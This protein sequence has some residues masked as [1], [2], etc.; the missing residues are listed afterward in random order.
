MSQ[1]FSFGTLLACLGEI[2]NVFS[3]ACPDKSV[4]DKFDTSFITGMRQGMKLLKG[5]KT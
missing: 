5:G 4:A 1:H 3:H 2:D